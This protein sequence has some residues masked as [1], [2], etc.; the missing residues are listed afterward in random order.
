MKTVFYNSHEFLQLL[1]GSKNIFLFYFL[2]P[3]ELLIKSVND[4]WQLVHR[5]KLTRNGTC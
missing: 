3:A 1:H 2:F 4:I 5:V